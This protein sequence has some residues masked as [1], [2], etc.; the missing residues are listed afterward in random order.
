[1]TPSPQGRRA[2]VIEDHDDIR[3][4]LAQTIGMR[5]FT[6]TTAA[7][8]LDGLEAVRRDGA[9]LITLDLNLPD[10]DGMEI[11]R[12][13]REFS[14]AYLLMVT[15]R[16]GEID[17]LRGLEL[18]ADDYISKPFSPRELQARIEAMFRRPR[19]RAE[20]ADA[21]EL[22]R[23]A[24]VQRSLLP[25]TAPAVPGYDVGGLCRPSR[26]V[27]GDFFDWYAT[28]DGLQVSLADA[29]GKGMGAA[30]IAATVRAVLRSAA[31]QPDM[32]Q[33]F[34]DTCRHL[35]N[36]LVHSGSFVT[37]FH[38]RLDT[39]RGTVDYVDAG[40]G[41]GLHVHAG[42][43][44]RLPSGGPPVGAV[45]DTEWASGSLRLA[46]GDAL[47]VVSDG[48]LDA[49]EDVEEA[50]RAVAAVV[51]EHPG[52]REA[53][54]AILDLVP[55]DAAADDVTAVLVRRRPTAPGGAL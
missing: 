24:E 6:V 31:G 23:A 21:E 32:A 13:V 12:R 49:F 8:G 11:C 42:G 9:D 40:H 2:V 37:L 43:A 5:G 52:S 22:R 20:Q 51:A 15:A 33:A 1:M 44:D 25:A 19:A 41:L 45:P 53:C 29:M 18:G 38:A 17:R 48:L 47:V 39:A 7:T 35:E 28:G 46:P 30:L 55:S 27:G 54:Q 36:D 14:D 34:R 10:L 3:N 4:L 50:V 26:S 16:P